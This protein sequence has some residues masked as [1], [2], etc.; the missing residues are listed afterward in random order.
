MKALDQ[1]LAIALDIA[2]MYGVTILL[3]RFA[4][5]GRSLEDAVWCI[6]W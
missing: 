2:A 4:V 1:Q 5:A 3:H 6:C